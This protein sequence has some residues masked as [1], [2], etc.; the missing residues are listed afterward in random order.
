MDL[1]FLAKSG[2]DSVLTPS[3]FSVSVWRFS[4]GLVRKRDIRPFAVSRFRHGH[5]GHPPLLPIDLV[6]FFIIIIILFLL[7]DSSG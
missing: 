1:G 5:R 7:E 2:L 6:F 4:L 3:N